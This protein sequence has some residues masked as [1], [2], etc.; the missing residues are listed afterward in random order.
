MKTALY[1]E[2][3]TD[4]K[5][6]IKIYVISIL[7]AFAA[8]TISAICAGGMKSA[9][10]LTKPPLMPPGWLFP[11]VW[12]ALYILMGVSAAAVYLKKNEEAKRAL[13]VYGVQLIVNIIW[14]PLYFMLKLRLA[15][16]IWILLLIAVIIIMIVRFRS[17]DKTAA[18][19]QIP[20]LVWTAFAA[21][22][23]LGTY[24]LNG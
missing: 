4:K 24:L 2:P 20:Y 3:N 12:T 1:T 7:I 8:G 10:S 17:V 22:L 23:N 14:T 18:Y 6:K 15:A 13:T 16:F 11:I 9:K 19:L 5:E 21:Y